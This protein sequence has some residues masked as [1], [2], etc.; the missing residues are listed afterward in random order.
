MPV[1]N[2]E[3][4]LSDAILSVLNQS[5]SDYEFI[6]IND[7][8]TDSSLE[9]INQHAANDL[10]IRIINKSHTGL[11]DS[12]NCGLETAKGEWVARIDADDICEP[13]RFR[14]QLEQASLIPNCILLGSGLT[15][16]DESSNKG[17][18]YR[19]PRRHRTLLH[20]LSTSRSP[21]AHS[22]ALFKASTARM[23]GGYRIRCD[24]SQDLDLWLRLA[25]HGKIGC[26]RE[27]LVQIRKH[28]MQISNDDGGRSQ[29]VYSYLST[30][31][32]WLRKIGE[33]DPIDSAS[34]NGF[35]LFY[36]WIL[37]RLAEEGV[38]QEQLLAAK[39]KHQ[40]KDSAQISPLSL[41]SLATLFRYS[42]FFFCR[43]SAF[44]LWG[45]G[46]SKRLAYEWIK[47]P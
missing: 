31:S 28:Q 6:I 41:L 29:L 33:N 45:S 19:F 26:I 23:L 36:D 14:K 24:H 37:R 34:E 12:L 13:N 32:Y 2:G 43:R 18:I 42:G 7:G 11:S 3:R 30:T 47:R 16:I 35:C 46:L 25:E 4:W 39:L 9:F 1:H 8:S 20:H 22:S 44:H 10:R 40:V 5:F 38:F 27:P 17:K 21:F 15:L